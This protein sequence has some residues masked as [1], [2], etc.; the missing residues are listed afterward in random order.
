V[1]LEKTTQ[2]LGSCASRCNCTEWARV[3]RDRDNR[4]CVTTATIYRRERGPRRFGRKLDSGDGGERPRGAG[5]AAPLALGE[6]PRL[7]TEL[8]DCGAWPSHGLPFAWGHQR[9]LVE[10]LCGSGYL[11]KNIGVIHESLHLYLALYL[12]HLY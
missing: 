5:S 4:I 2:P 9:G 6:G 8:L 1:S 12:P 10:S 3:L 11:D 7:S